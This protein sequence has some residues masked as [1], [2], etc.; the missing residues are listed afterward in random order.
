[1]K[2]LAYPVSRYRAALFSN[3]ETVIPQISSNTDVIFQVLSSSCVWHDIISPTGNA[4]SK[5]QIYP[6]YFSNS[7]KNMWRCLQCDVLGF[8]SLTF[9]AFQQRKI[10]CILT[11]SW[12][13]DSSGL[14]S[15]LN[16]FCKSQLQAI[17]HGKQLQHDWNFL[18]NASDEHAS[19]CALTY[20]SNV[21]HV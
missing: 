14:L 15:S 20:Y 2:L 10:C 21:V 11:R 7:S 5:R 8:F 9:F 17:T 18:T 1:M 6:F 3:Q 12:F 16:P 19:D 13:W 4:I